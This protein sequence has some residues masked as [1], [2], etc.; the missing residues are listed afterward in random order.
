MQEQVIYNYGALGLILIGLAVFGRWFLRRLD[1]EKQERREERERERQERE[2]M[3]KGFLES[4]N[5]FNVTLY[6]HLAHQEA[7]FEAMQKSSQEQSQRVL[8]ALERLCLDL[9]K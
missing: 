3:V 1:C 5:A 2:A 6:N 7:A 4:C 8:D 9:G